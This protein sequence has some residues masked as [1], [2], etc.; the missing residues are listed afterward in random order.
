MS[1]SRLLGAALAGVFFIGAIGCGPKPEPAAVPPAPNKNASETESDMAKMKAEVAK[2]SPE[3]AA[4]VTKQHNCPVTDEMLG[5][6]GPP[7]KVAVGDKQV[8]ICCEACRK[9]LLANQAKYLAKLPK[10]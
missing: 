10:S 2:L 1:N 6:M 5:S 3:D 8:W 7:L 4:A 9:E